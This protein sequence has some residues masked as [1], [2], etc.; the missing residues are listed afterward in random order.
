M[1]GLIYAFI[2]PIAAVIAYNIGVFCLVL[3]VIYNVRD[4]HSDGNDAKR[5]QRAK[6]SARASVAFMPVMGIT[7]VFGLLA[8]EPNSGIVW[9]YLF[10]ICTG[11][12][13]ILI[14]VFHFAADRTVRREVVHCLGI[15]RFLGD[16]SATGEWSTNV[17][18][19]K[20]DI[21]SR[22]RVE[23]AR[24]LS[25]RTSYQVGWSN[26]AQADAPPNPPLARSSADGSRTLLIDDRCLSA[27][28]MVPTG[29]AQDAARAGSRLAESDIDY[30]SVVAAESVRSSSPPMIPPV[31]YESWR[32]RLRDRSGEAASGM[33][34][35]EWGDLSRTA[36]MESVLSGA[37]EEELRRERERRRTA[38]SEEELRQRQRHLQREVDMHLGLGEMDHLV[39]FDGPSAASL[40]SAV[41]EE[42]EKDED[43]GAI[44]LQQQQRR[45]KSEWDVAALGARPAGAGR[46]SL[47]STSTQSLGVPPASG[48]DPLWRTGSVHMHL[49]DLLL[50]MRDMANPQQDILAAERGLGAGRTGAW[51][52]EGGAGSRAV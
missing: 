52:D 33:E 36:S 11:A 26:V 29:A 6:R 50:S 39:I 4:A 13:G 47:K 32:G 20:G 1:A 27:E 15:G 19:L 31:E 10:T 3:R 45:S 42:E 24:I 7:W 14:F 18:D 22:V 34:E 12:Q 48:A 43:E 5:M 8:I 2:G 40:A 16:R 38:Q 51:A 46:G 17:T 30:M 25:E 21:K 23:N 28:S 37:A 44:M 35:S 41:P 49:D 9:T